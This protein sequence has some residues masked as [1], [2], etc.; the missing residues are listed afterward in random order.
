MS[1]KLKE[2]YTVFSPSPLQPSQ[3]AWYVD[4]E[5]V[6]GN[7]GIVHR[8]AQ[9]VRLA[10]APTCQVL[11]GH[12]GSGKSTELSRLRQA[13]QETTSDSRFFVVQIQ[14]D[15]ELDRNDI[16]FPEVL[17]AIV[18]QLAE[19]L[20][21][22]E[23]IE[24]KPG[25][26][27]DR[28]ERLKKLALT[29]VEFDKLELGASFAKLGATIKNSPDA[30]QQIR[31]ALEP[32]TTNWLTAAND[33]IGQAIKELENKGYRGL[34]VI[35][36]DLDKMITRP[37]E[38]A[39]CSTTEYLFIHR[40]PQMTAFQ[41]HLIYTLPIELAYSH[42]ESTIK[43]LYGGHL[44]V[45][46]MTKLATRPP[47]SKTYTNGIKKFREIIAARLK[48][49]D[50]TDADLFQTNKVRDDLIKLTGGQP[51]ELMGMVREAIVTDGLPIGSAGLKRCR[52]EAM[53]SYRRQ[54]RSD[55][56]PL[57][58]EVYRTGVFVRTLENETAF[59]E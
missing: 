27:R 46:P 43:R 18:R 24:L 54:L 14:A 31:K 17:I 33:V 9:K 25:Y 34:V 36:D 12:R 28:W 1:S 29:E 35:F 3:N 8:M 47:N 53:R 40:S 2:I 26:F 51:T 44:P 37:Y 20:R 16:D 52:T 19:Q 6:R 38:L 41:C 49:V 22:R 21:A 5:D 58:E 50:A 7:M 30:R 42:H 23:N 45:V 10:D 57:I 15:N 55:H 56:W 4:L 13:L 59:R 39:G 32:D 11:T 48:S